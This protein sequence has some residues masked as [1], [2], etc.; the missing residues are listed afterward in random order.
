MPAIAAAMPTRKVRV[1]C[2]R[3]STQPASVTKIGAR[4]ARS[5]ALAIDV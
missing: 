1:T 2:C 3:H 4:F 5:V